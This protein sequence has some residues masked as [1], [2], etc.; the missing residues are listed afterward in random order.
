[1]TEPWYLCNMYG[2]M[3]R[4]PHA[5]HWAV[6]VKR[7]AGIGAVDQLSRYLELINRDPLL[8][9]VGGILAGQSVTAQARKLAADRG[10][11][12]VVLDYDALRGV[13]DERLRLF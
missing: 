6:E 11:R 1:M 2:P 4:I 7:R 9:P 10:I 5:R 3:S 8:A 12:V 13:E